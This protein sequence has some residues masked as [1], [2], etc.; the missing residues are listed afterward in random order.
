VQGGSKKALGNQACKMVNKAPRRVLPAPW[1]NVLVQA[2][3]PRGKS[4][5]L[6]SILLLC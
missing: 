3:S 5:E 4:E 1:Y 2:R 6:A